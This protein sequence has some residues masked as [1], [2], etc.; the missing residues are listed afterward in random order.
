M[1][2]NFVLI[3]EMILELEV[4]SVKECIEGVTDVV[5]KSGTLNDY[6]HLYN[7]LD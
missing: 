7:Y 1:Y 2:I 6:H 5:I 4:V 3:E